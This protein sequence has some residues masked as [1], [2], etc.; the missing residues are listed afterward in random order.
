MKKQIQFNLLLISILLWSAACSRK[1]FVATP[2]PPQYDKPVEIVKEVST[3]DIPIEVQMSVLEQQMTEKLPNPFYEDNSL[4][5]NNGDNM[6]IRVTRRAPVRI[7]T[8]N[9]NFI[10]TV[11][12]H[13]WSKVGWKMEQFGVSLSK[14]EDVDFDIDI[15]FVSKVTIGS[16]WKVKTRT[17]DNGFDWV[18]KPVVKIGMFSIPV[19]S[20]VEKIIDDQL[21]AVAKL[22]DQQVADKVDLKPYVLDAWNSLQ[23]PLLVNEEYEAW[24]KITPLELMMTPFVSKG[25]N[26]S[27]VVGLKARTETVLGAKPVVVPNPTL[28]ALQIATTPVDSKFAVGLI[29]EVPYSQAKKMAMKQVAGQVYEFQEGKYK[30][31]VTDMELYGQ[32]DYLIVMAALKGSL[33]GKV[34]LRGKPAYDAATRSVVIKELDYDLDTKN[35]LIKTADWLAHGKFLKMM[36]PFFTVSLASQLDEAQKMIQQNLANNKLDNGISIKGKLNEL[37]PQNIF[38]TPTAIQTIIR[39]QGNIDVLVS[40]P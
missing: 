3:L 10:F 5:D 37:S 9:G 6:M 12:V 23:T 26:A 33:N 20:I 2:P 7:E 36:T 35:R 31:E 24:L 17:S 8:R 28:P 39:A 1:A 14:Y 29:A 32:G 13:I 16:D 34:Y 15:K 21:P 38:V 11:P 19:T 30:I 18:S 4:E 25:K 27:F 22:I 40:N